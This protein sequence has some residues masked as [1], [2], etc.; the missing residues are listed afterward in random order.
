MLIVISRSPLT[1]AHCWVLGRSPN[2]VLR[3]HVDLLQ[4]HR[5]ESVSS[6]ST[7]RGELSLSQ[8]GAAWNPLFCSV[9]SLAADVLRQLETA[10]RKLLKE[11]SLSCLALDRI[12][13]WGAA[14]CNM[15]PTKGQTEVCWYLFMCRV[16][17]LQ[18]VV[19]SPLDWV[20]CFDCFYADVLC[21]VRVCF[22]RVFDIVCCFGIVAL[23][24]IRVANGLS[25]VL[26]GC[27]D[28][29]MVAPA[30]DFPW[31]RSVS[32]DSKKKKTKSTFW[33]KTWGSRPFQS[34]G[35]SKSKDLRQSKP[36]MAQHAWH[37][38][39]KRDDFLVFFWRVTLNLDLAKG[40]RTQ[41]AWIRAGG[42]DTARGPP[43][44]SS[45]RVLSLHQKTLNQDEEQQGQTKRQRTSKLSVATS[46]YQ[47]RDHRNSSETT[48]KQRENIIQRQR[49][50]SKKTTNCT[51]RKS[52]QGYG[53]LSV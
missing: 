37:M 39:H 13:F 10:W 8:S 34:Q 24:S 40:P 9:R 20:R 22:R 35:S 36:Q 6:S 1:G 32:A 41:K 5:W 11:C 52:Q 28:E 16:P 26:E 44:T 18:W 25:F 33:M 30:R 46:S 31:E 21:Y 23:D 29:T 51:S 7:L 17:Q 4:K 3:A 2:C 15:L 19:S 14:V 48:R 47:S 53:I 50:G 45:R 27:L 42:A 43:A 12:Y 49:M 38:T